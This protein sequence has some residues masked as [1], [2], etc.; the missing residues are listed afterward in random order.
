MSSVSYG[1]GG[2]GIP[3]AVDE[4]Y[5]LSANIEYQRVHQR[6]TVLVTRITGYLNERGFGG[7]G[8][9]GGEGGGGDGAED[10]TY[11][12]CSNYYNINTVVF[13]LIKRMIKLAQENSRP[14]IFHGVS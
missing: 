5:G 4:P 9:G 10:N 1:A 13:M 12:L 2:R 14:R 8:G 6:H 7:G 3:L 11:W